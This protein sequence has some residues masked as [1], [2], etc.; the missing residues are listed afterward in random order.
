MNTANPTYTRDEIL[1][2]VAES[3]VDPF[4][5]EPTDATYQ[6]NYLLAHFGIEVAK[7]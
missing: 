7:P 2:I 5:K 4:R 3:Q 6:L 1:K